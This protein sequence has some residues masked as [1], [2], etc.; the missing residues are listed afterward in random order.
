[1]PGRIRNAFPA[2]E[3]RLSPDTYIETQDELFTLLRKD[4]ERHFLA[5]G[6]DQ[7]GEKWYTV[8]SKKDPG[9][10]SFLIGTVD[11]QLAE[12]YF[13]GG[14]VSMADPNEVSLLIP[15]PKFCSAWV[16]RVE[17]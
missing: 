15:S 6:L 8:Q 3:K 12:K 5:C 4:P 17:C 10:T 16:P 2:N 14:G 9:D 1:M 13:G 11:P 7:E